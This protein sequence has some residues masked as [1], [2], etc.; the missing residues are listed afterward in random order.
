MPKYIINYQAWWV[1]EDDNGNT[2]TH[3][4]ES[5]FDKEFESLEEA[6][7]W[8]KEET[9]RCYHSHLEWEEFYCEGLKED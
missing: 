9:F 4:E 7:K 8:C 5:F 3:T 2:E 6:R 1:T